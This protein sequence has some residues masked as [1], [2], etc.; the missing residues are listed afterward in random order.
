MEFSLYR[1]LKNHKILFR[2]IRAWIKLNLPVPGFIKRQ[3]ANEIHA[4]MIVR[5][6]D[7]TVKNGR[8]TVDDALKIHFQLG[9][10]ISSQ[11]REFLS[12]NPEDAVSL[13]KIIDFLHDLLLI[14]GKKTVAASR[15]SATSHWTKC[16]LYK[17]LLN[18][19]NGFYYCHLYQEMYKGVLYGINPKARANTLET[20]RSMHC[21]YCEL[22]TWI[23][24]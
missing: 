1:Y 19:E 4:E 5:L 20:T 6:M 12:V 10:E 15:T 3:L 11:V 7:F 9:I 18:S 14:K 24:N 16:S 21:D 17:Q 8:L 22:I 2:L 23:E 13:A